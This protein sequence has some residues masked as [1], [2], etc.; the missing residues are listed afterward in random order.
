MKN[1]LIIAI[2]CFVVAGLAFAS[3]CE[4]ADKRSLYHVGASAG[5]ATIGE[6]IMLQ[7]PTAYEDR[8]IRRTAV[9]GGCIAVGAAKEFVYD[10]EADGEDLF[11]DAI[12]CTIPIVIGETFFLT[13][14]PNSI[15]LAGR[16]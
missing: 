4:S 6:T 13:A 12:G 3:L 9:F 8:Y 2:L 1:S 10:A 11:F 16:W 5:I 7:S 15:S 14:S